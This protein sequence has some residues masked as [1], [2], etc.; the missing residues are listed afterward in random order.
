MGRQNASLSDNLSFRQWG[1]LCGSN[2]IM[3]TAEDY[4]KWMMFHLSG[5][6]NQAGQQVM[7]RDVV[8]DMHRPRNTI[9]SASVAKYFT[10]PSVPV[11][12]SENSYAL[13]WKNG[14]YRGRHAHVTQLAKYQNSDSFSRFQ[15]K[16]R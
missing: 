9:K 3:S 7:D 8:T 5:G 15:N 2:C 12:T 6:Q 1:T 13:G 4:A 10:K 16:F 14:Y 11:T